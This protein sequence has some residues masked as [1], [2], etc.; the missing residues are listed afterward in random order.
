MVRFSHSSQLSDFAINI[1]YLAHPCDADGVFLPD[2][3]LPLIDAAMPSTS[4][5]APFDGREQFEF[6]EWAFVHNQSSTD[7]I[8]QLLRIWAANNLQNGTEGSEPFADYDKL[9]KTID[10]ISIGES[11]WY[12]F[13]LCCNTPI[14]E[15]SAL[16]K[17]W[18]YIVHTCDICTV[19]CN[20]VGTPKFA[21]KF[22]YA[23]YKEYTA[24]SDCLYSD[25]MSGQWASN[26]LVCYSYF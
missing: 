25:F 24:S 1:L 4:D 12:S 11:T 2:R 15:D 9:L 14:T 6:A 20:I 5:F 19:I 17:T 23:A 16:W 18:K 21:N 3:A 22:D 7:D 26:E 10:T 13:S 8:N